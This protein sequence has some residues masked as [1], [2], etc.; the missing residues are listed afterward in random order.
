M[1]IQIGKYQVTSDGHHN[2]IVQEQIKVKSKETGE[3]REV[4]GKTNYFTKLE[5]LGKWMLDQRILKSQAQSIEELRLE[6]MAAK[7]EIVE[8][9]RALNREE[10]A[11]G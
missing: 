10:V 1:N 3:I 8:E 9:I 4:L 11:A 7:M 2:L 5:H 6:V